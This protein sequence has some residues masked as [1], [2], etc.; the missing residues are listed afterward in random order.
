MI[1]PQYIVAVTDIGSGQFKVFVKETEISFEFNIYLNDVKTLYKIK[2]RFQSGKIIELDKEQYVLKINKQ[3]QTVIHF[4]RK[5]SL[6]NK[7]QHV[8]FQRWAYLYQKLIIEKDT[9]KSS[10]EM[11]KI[12]KRLLYFTNHMI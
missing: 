4:F 11:K 5:N 9:D 7:Y 2:K 1:H 8:K 10:K 12:K 6:L 3:L